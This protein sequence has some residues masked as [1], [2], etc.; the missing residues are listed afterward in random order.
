MLS[1]SLPYARR[2]AAA[3]DALASSTSA[4]RKSLRPCHGVS[5]P[6]LFGK[7]ANDVVGRHRLV[8]ARELERRERLR[9][10]ELR[11]HPLRAFAQ[12]DLTAEGL[13]T[14]PRREV[15]HATDG[16]VVET[17]IEA[18]PPE[19]RV[20]ERD[21]HAEVELVTALTPAGDE[22]AHAFAHRDRH[23]DGLSRGIRARDGVVEEREDRVAGEALERRPESEHQLAER[24]V[25]LAQDAHDLLRLGDLGERGEPAE[26]AEHDGDLAAVALE[27]S[28]IAG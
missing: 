14:E 18:D 10:H 24:G 12:E 23:P 6:G 19:R 4:V 20:A 22:R 25:V 5:Q 3:A 2:P 8:E 11:H 1:F 9:H 21:P 17:T 7:Q 28:L 13:G 26:V 27:Q 16:A 15:H